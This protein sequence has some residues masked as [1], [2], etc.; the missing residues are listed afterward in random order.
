M[1]AGSAKPSP[2]TP[3]DFRFDNKNT[4]KNRRPAGPTV[5]IVHVF[6]LFVCGCMGKVKLG[7][8]SGGNSGSDVGIV[9]GALPIVV[10]HAVTNCDR[11]ATL[12]TLPL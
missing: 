7:G 5:F 8:G 11:G 9:V 6:V 3:G 4:S 1:V 2:L 12:Q 10:L